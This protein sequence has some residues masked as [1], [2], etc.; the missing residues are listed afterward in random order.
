MEQSFKKFIEDI[1][2]EMVSP[3][4]TRTQ[5]KR[6]DRVDNLQT[7]RRLMHQAID[8]LPSTLREKGWS[9]VQYLDQ[10]KVMLS[11]K[12]EFI[13]FEA[14]EAIPG[15]DILALIHY[16]LRKPRNAPNPIGWSAFYEQLKTYD[17]QP[18]ILSRRHRIN[19]AEPMD[20]TSVV[21]RT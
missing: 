15:S 7:T 10:N 5:Q 18:G 2:K 13:P 17:I 16:A 3:P 21:L 1:I 12:G 6:R 19:T 14:K 20:T 9:L 8:N 4:V 11:A